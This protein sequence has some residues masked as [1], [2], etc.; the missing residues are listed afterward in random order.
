MFS[1][2]LTSRIANQFPQLIVGIKKYNITAENL[3]NWDEKGFIIGHASATQRIMLL[4]AFKSERIQYASEDGNREFISLLACISADGTALPPALIYKGDSLYLQDTWLEDWVPAHKA[5]F[6]ISPN[7]W[8]CN[9]LGLNWLETVF[10]RYTRQKAGNRRRMLLVDGH[11]SHVNMAF[12]NACD[13]LRIL[14]MILPPHATHRLQPLDVS[15]FSPLAT[16]YTNG[17]NDL[18]FKSLG[19]VSMSKRLF[20][21]IF[22]PAWNQ[23]F[24]VENIA[25]A[26]RNTGVWPYNPAIILDTITIPPI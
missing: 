1:I 4:E 6:A 25:S 11:S 21:K 10:D 24:S 14:L 17:L 2:C 9:A 26:Y 15:L 12:I 22:W 23:A 7:G 8:S 19:L 20:W 3:Y 13:R 16:Y 5:H 18:M